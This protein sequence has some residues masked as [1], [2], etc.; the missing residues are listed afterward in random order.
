MQ[1]QK[2]KNVALCLLWKNISSNIN[3]SLSAGR[4]QTPALRLIYDNYIELKDKINDNEVIFDLCKQLIIYFINTYT[5]KNDIEQNNPN[6]DQRVN[7]I[8]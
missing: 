5:Y 8:C 7:L 4:C 2:N 1:E 3:N 6:L